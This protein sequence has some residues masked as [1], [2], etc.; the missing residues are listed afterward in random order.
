MKIETGR[1]PMTTKV[2]IGVRQPQATEH[3]KLLANPQKLGFRVSLALSHL[4]SGFYPP[5]L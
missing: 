5:E 4:I 2:E 1:I 3:Q